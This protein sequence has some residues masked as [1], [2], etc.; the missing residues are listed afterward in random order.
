MKIFFSNSQSFLRSYFHTRSIEGF[1]ENDHLQV[2]LKLKAY[3][4]IEFILIKLAIS[5]TDSSYVLAKLIGS[6]FEEFINR[7]KP[8]IK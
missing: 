3:F 8:S 6:K 7:I 2:I 1:L 5:N 4:F